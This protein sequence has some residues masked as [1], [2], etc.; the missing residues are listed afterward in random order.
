[1]KI[2]GDRESD[3]RA[4]RKERQSQRLIR[5]LRGKSAL[6]SYRV[7]DMEVVGKPIE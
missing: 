3:V 5:S 1:M 2:G 7:E 4:E 6:R